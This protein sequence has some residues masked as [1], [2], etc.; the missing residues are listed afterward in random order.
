MRIENIAEICESAWYKE[1]CSRDRKTRTQLAG[2]EGHQIASSPLHKK[3]S[4]SRPG[5]YRNLTKLT[6]APAPKTLW[7]LQTIHHDHFS[8]PPI[9]KFP[10]SKISMT[11]AHKFK[12][13]SILFLRS[14]VPKTITNREFQT[15]HSRRTD[16]QREIRRRRNNTRS[17]SKPNILKYFFSDSFSFVLSKRYYY[18]SPG[19]SRKRKNNR[20]I[21]MLTRESTWREK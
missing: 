16:T 8:V 3:R 6:A 5:F 17:L 1:L 9:E 11:H 18:Y 10:H 4:H 15:L 7:K 13:S 12:Y 2:S 19:L 14:F 21:K 20:I